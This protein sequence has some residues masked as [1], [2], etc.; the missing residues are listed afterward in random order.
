MTAL[1]P[2]LLDPKTLTRQVWDVNTARQIPGVGRALDLIGGLGSQMP[3]DMFAGIMPLERPRLLEDPDLEYVRPLFVSLQ[4]EDYLVHGNAAHLVTARGRDGWPAACRWYPASSWHVA[5]ESGRR[6]WWLNGR[7]VDTDD[8]VHVPNGADPLA[9]YRGVGLIERFARSLDRV[10]LQEAR[11]RSDTMGGNVPS[12]A[13]TVPQTDPDEDELDA[14]AKKWEEK[15]QGPGR[16]PVILPNG[17]VV[18]P[19]GWSPNDAEATKARQA[20]L[21]DVANMFNLDGYWLGAPASSHTYRTPGVLFLVMVR[22]TLNRIVV[23]FEETW[24][25]YWLPRGRK[26]RF[27]RSAIESDDL[28][29]IVDMLV[30]ATGGPVMTVNEGRTVLKLAPVEGGNELRTAAAEPEPDP[31]EQ[32]PEDENDPEETR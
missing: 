16:R 26:V 14:A 30:K 19:L 6:R 13:V 31:P 11:E 1:Y 4:L 23:P 29:T 20:S 2:S 10:A 18:T 25:K 7:E 8:V 5:V 21:T 3:L 15:F 24:S 28:K 9:P 22:T 27:D 12:V 32:D 17:T